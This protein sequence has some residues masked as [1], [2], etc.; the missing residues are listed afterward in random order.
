MLLTKKENGAGGKADTPPADWFREKLELDNAYLDKHLI[1]ADP[2]LWAL[3]RFDDFI[4][5]RQ[6]LI[7]EKFAYLLP[8][9]K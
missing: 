3:E 7:R 8:A 6:K 5:A 4:T 1:P 9:T 2:S